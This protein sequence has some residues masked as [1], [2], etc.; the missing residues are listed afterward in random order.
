MS[1]INKE[2]YKAVAEIHKNEL[3]GSDFL[4]SCSKKIIGYFYRCYEKDEKNILFTVDE[5]GEIAGFVFFTLA[6][7]GLF[8]NF[9]KRNILQILLSPSAFYSLFKTMIMRKKRTLKHQY[10]VDIVYIAVGTKFRSKG[11]ARKLLGM[12]EE[13]LKA[14]L[15]CTY[16]LQVFKDNHRAVE[17]YEKYGFETIEEYSARGR[18]KLLMRKNIQYE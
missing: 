18:I 14:H 13:Y 7:D 2:Y 12:V 8:S 3:G 5:K 9:V 11:Y 15:I 10:D 1:E 16:C 4:S 17:F 6:K